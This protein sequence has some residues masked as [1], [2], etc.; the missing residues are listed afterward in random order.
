MGGREGVSGRGGCVDGVCSEGVSGMVGVGGEGVCGW[1]ILVT[2]N[3]MPPSHSMT[4]NTIS[5]ILSHHYHIT[6][7]IN[8]IIV[9]Y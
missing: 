1:H 8:V 9:G 4:K 6:V 5:N 7:T 2:V 3:I